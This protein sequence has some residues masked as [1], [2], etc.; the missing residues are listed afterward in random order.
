MGHFSKYVPP[1]ALRIYSSNALGMVTAA[2]LNPDGSKSLVA[3]ND[4]ASTQSFSI[5]WGTQ[6]FAYT[7]PS[8]AGATFTWTGVQGS[9]TTPATSQIQA[10]SFKSTGG[11]NTLGDNTTFGLQTETT[12]DT[13]GGYDLGFS[14]DGDYAVYTNVDFG[15]GVSGVSARLACAGNCG[16]PLEFHLD[17]VSGPLAASVTIPATAGWQ[18]WNTAA[19]PASA[20]GVHDL[21]V[22]F[23]AAP[24][25]SSSLGNFNWF[26]FN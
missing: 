14:S 23:K 16:G 4:S 19:A 18:T 22:V 6:S 2:F 26:Q 25:G 11:N 12:S 20:S 7:L 3:F 21:Y 15:A 10:S 8:L 9:Y 1:G 13:N 24:G 17:S 5:Q